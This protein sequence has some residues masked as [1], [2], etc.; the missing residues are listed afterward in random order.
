MN[1]KTSEN[2]HINVEKHGWL[3][4][5]SS[6]LKRL[7]RKSITEKYLATANK[8][9][10]A[11]KEYVTDFSSSYSIGDYVGIKV[12]QVDRTNI[13]PKILPSVVVEINDGKVKVACECGVIDQWWSLDSVVK[14]SN[15]P[16]ALFNLKIQKL[17]KVFIITASKLFVRGDVNDA[18]CS[19]KSG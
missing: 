13:D 18:T 16:D 8:R 14:L 19:G 10:K 3:L 2:L 12:D 4:K 15:V 17:R 11:Y 9:I 5:E 6:G 7:I 1:C